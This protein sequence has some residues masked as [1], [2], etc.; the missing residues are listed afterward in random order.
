MVISKEF[1]SAFHNAKNAV[2]YIRDYL[3]YDA[4]AFCNEGGEIIFENKD[5][6]KMHLDGYDWND[7][8]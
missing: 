1:E 6:D 4:D 5:G 8:D 3:C 2:S 7:C